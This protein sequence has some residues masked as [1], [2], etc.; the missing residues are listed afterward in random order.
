MVA[1]KLKIEKLIKRKDNKWKKINIEVKA[2][3]LEQIIAV[4]GFNYKVIEGYTCW[5]SYIENQYGEVIA[6]GD[7]K[8]QLQSLKSLSENLIDKEISIGTIA[9]K[10]VAFGHRGHIIRRIK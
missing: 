9:L 2:P 5:H 10:D 4:F 3:T 8:T 7:G 6:F 1:K